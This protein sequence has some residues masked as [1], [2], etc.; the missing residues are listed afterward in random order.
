MML[1]VSRTGYG[2]KQYWVKGGLKN[3]T[4]SLVPERTFMGVVTDAKSGLNIPFFQIYSAD[5]DPKKLA[6]GKKLQPVGVGRD[7]VL[8][9]TA[10]DSG[11]APLY[12][13][14]EALG[15]APSE[16]YSRQ[17]LEESVPLAIQLKPL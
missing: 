3:L 6:P 8:R 13:R 1:R 12:Y 7:G 11:G 2:F 9:V 14:V 17:R 10:T 16:L 15:Y 5:L 4:V